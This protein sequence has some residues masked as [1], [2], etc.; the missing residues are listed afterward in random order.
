MRERAFQHYLSHLQVERGLASNT[1]E[2]YRRD[3][4][5]FF[6]FLASQQWT[7]EE[8]GKEHLTQYLQ[9]LYERLSVR[10][11]MRK[12]VSLRS[13]FRFLLLDGYLHEDPTETLE[14]PKTGRTLPQ[15]L[16][17]E[18]VEQLLK[19]PDVTTPYGLRDKAMLEVLYATGLR[20]SELVQ[21]RLE[22]M[23]LEVGWI[24]TFGKGSKERI[25]PVGSSA[26]TFIQQYIDEARGCFLIKHTPSP[27]LFL[28]QRGR[29]M[30]RQYF[31][32]LVTKY[33]K[34]IGINKRLN[35]HMLRHSFATHLLENGA[36]LRAV[37]LMLGHA[38]IS[39]TQIYTH[40]TRERLKKI[41]NEY[42]P[43][44]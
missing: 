5:E 38:D 16:A 44:A 26:I 31:W 33:G 13:F 27:Y 1:V 17:E 18:E 30:T 34:Q 24:R 4:L 42:H 11:V 39:T 23:N 8:V 20:V 12:I 32:M 36:N 29:S 14:S 3:L 22:E 7:I 43:R 41:Y 35:P 6:S 2:A 40:V 28:T 37:Q 21:I 15:Y 10:S 9:H 25:V 19:Q